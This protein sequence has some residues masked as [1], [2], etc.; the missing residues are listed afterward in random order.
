MLRLLERSTFYTRKAREGGNTKKQKS[1]PEKHYHVVFR[2]IN[3]SYV[4]LYKPLKLCVRSEGLGRIS[5]LHFY[6][7]INIIT[8]PWNIR[9]HKKRR[10]SVITFLG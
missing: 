3:I 8:K 4:I 7:I 1:V 6:E 5:L 9:P 10:E 2:V